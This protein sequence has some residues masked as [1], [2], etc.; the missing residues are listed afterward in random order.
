MSY[1]N[2]MK[3]KEVVAG[4]WLDIMN[5]EGR[6]WLNLMGKVQA[7]RERGGVCS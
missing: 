4:V 5:E 6:M 7:A 2:L 1:Q 3:Q